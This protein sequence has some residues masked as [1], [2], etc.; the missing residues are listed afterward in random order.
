ME[1]EN[2]C[3]ELLFVGRGRDMGGARESA[4]ARRSVGREVFCFFLEVF[5]G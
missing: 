4:R 5:L 1:M 2:T 3:R